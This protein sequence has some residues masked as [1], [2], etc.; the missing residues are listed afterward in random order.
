M[1]LT[2]QLAV[3]PEQRA[4]A[5][6]FRY[7]VWVEELEQPSRF[8][9]HYEKQLRDDLDDFAHI[10]IAQDG[11]KIVGTQRIN[12]ASQGNL[13]EWID[14]FGLRELDSFF[15][16]A[17]SYSSRLMIASSH[18]SSALSSRLN[19]RC[20]EIGTNFGVCFDF[21]DCR[22]HFMP[23]FSRIGYRVARTEL[24]AGEVVPMVLL[25]HDV[26]YMKQCRSPFLWSVKQTRCDRN[27]VEHAKY[28]SAPPL[29]AGSYPAI[30]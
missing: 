8:A 6:K 10:V 23:Y 1:P 25:T 30:R 16:Q 9:N 15:P 13:G 28:F 26:L 11:E 5:F 12:V 3:S 2:L 22:E 7:Q 27:C 14:F 24:D 19:R 4:A 20:Y 17:I 29:D 18:R 21:I